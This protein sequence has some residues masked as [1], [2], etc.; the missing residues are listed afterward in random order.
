MT[1]TNRGMIRRAVLKNVRDDGAMQ[2]AS[3]EVADG[4]W[5]DNVE[6]MQPYGFAAHVPEDGALAIVLAVGGDEGDLVVL[7]VANPSARMGGLKEGEVGCYNKS[8]D[9]MILQADGTLDIK[10]GAQ[11]TIQTDAGV[12]ITAQIVKV[13]GD[14]EAT[15]NV[16]DKNGSMQEMRDRYNGHNHAG[17]PPPSPNMD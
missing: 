9:R 15:G 5:R 2:T 14:I 17:G 4:V 16:T 7:P 10:T 6:I 12:F 11:I 13:T 1:D 8:G 3:V